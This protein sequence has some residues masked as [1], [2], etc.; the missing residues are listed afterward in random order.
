MEHLFKLQQYTFDVKEILL[1]HPK[2][3]GTYPK[4]VETIV[5]QKWPGNRTQASGVRGF[6]CGCH[7]GPTVGLWTPC[8]L[9]SC[10]H[11]LASLALSSH[12]VLI[13]PYNIFLPP[14]PSSPLIPSSPL[15]ISLIGSPHTL[16]ILLVVAL[17]T[18]RCHVYTIIMIKK[19]QKQVATCLAFFDRN[20]HN[21]WGEGCHMLWIIVC[22]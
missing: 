14:S 9:K 13:A 4:Y 7:K 17:V 11:S 15:L 21:L 8:P 19:V 18:S 6:V 10:S 12:S 1:I 20:S 16:L 5:L 22:S 3:L 2:Y